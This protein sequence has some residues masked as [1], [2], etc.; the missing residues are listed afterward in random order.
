MATITLEVID[1]LIA[2]AMAKH[3]VPP[4]T[5]APPGAKP[6]PRP[7]QPQ[8]PPRFDAAV[9]LQAEKN[10]LGIKSDDT[11]RFTLDLAGRLMYYRPDGRTLYAENDST[12]P[13]VSPV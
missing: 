1:R 9:Q 7:S 8:A 4:S 5:V 11:R 13:P 10:R 6:L 2:N 12:V 3:P